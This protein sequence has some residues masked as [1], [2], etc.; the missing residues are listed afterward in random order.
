MT[1]HDCIREPDPEAPSAGNASTCACSQ[2][3][4]L[5][6]YDDAEA[7]GPGGE[8][9]SRTIEYCA[10][11]PPDLWKP[12]AATLAAGKPGRANPSPFAQQWSA[13]PF[14]PRNAGDAPRRRASDGINS[15]VVSLDV[16]LSS[17][18][19][20]KPLAIRLGWPLFKTLIGTADDMCCVHAA[21][22]AH[23]NGYGG[24]TAPCVPGNCP[25]S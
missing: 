14:V 19:G 20:R 6:V 22:Q 5:T 3:A 13:V 25:V 12:S 1:V 2:W 17:L 24:G 4:V 10:V 23:M 16:D 18:Q 15:G 8:V 21:S 9:G 11:G 7:A